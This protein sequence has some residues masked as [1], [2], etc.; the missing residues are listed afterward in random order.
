MVEAE[1]QTG[2]LTRPAMHVGVDAERPAVAMEAGATA[3]RHARNPGRQIS[4][5]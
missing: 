4:D 5:P 1:H 3:S 2:P